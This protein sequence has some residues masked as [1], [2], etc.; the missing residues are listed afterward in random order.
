MIAPTHTT[1]PQNVPHDAEAETWVIGSAILQPSILDDLGWLHTD[2][3]FA[4]DLRQLYGAMVEARR[5][6]EP[7]DV[8]LLRKQFTG[9]DWAARIAEICHAV[10]VAAHWRRYAELVVRLA[11]LRRLAA[12]C[13]SGAA[14]AI[15]G[16]A[17]PDEVLER[18]ETDL[19]AMRATGER[20][21]PVTIFD[22]AM[23]A[24]ER[25]DAIIQRGHGGGLPT[26]LPKFDLDQGGLF[27]GELTV[28]AARPGCGKTSLAL[29]IAAH[30]ANRGR[31]V[32]FASLEMSAVE[33]ATRWACG[34]S[35]VSNRLVRIG[36]LTQD[37]TAR[38]AEAFDRQARASLEIH[39]RSCLTVATIRR[40]I[41]KR[42]KRG[43]ALAVVDYLQLVTPADR[44]LPREQQVAGMVRGLKETA[45]E[46]QIPIL[47]LCQLNRMAD[48]DDIPRLSH[49]RESG[50][51]E[52]DADVVL[53]LSRHEPT[54]AEPH[55]AILT[56]AKNRNGE[57]GSLRM[58]WDPSRTR[59]SCWQPEPHAEFAR[60]AG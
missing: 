2:D 58:T 10:P 29:Q 34:E 41:R 50:A 46:Y 13:E 11:K 14:D 21:E 7:I 38:L 18:V 4:D 36:K 59:F 55:N 56:I 30:N 9:D 45:L 53:F 43:L 57:V 35:G 22:A 44:R 15:K 25:I 51:I 52:Q 23:A 8:A 16:E 40:E 31:M 39:D 5:R 6:G 47:C 24:N 60:F 33:L 28:L 19:A 3:F 17:E 20:G 26:G 48:G 27:P 1:T 54:D 12:I 32:Y 49:L 37:D 42:V